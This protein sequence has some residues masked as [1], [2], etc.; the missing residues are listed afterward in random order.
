[1]VKAMC[2]IIQL[3][4]ELRSLNGVNI[5]EAGDPS[6]ADSR[7]IALTNKK[8]FA[9]IFDILIHKVPCNIG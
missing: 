3:N 5:M 9:C 6:S 2:P 7:Q 4:K 8:I 1:M